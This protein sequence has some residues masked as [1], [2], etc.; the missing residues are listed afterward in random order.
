MKRV[1]KI[2]VG[3]AVL[4]GILL[5]GGGVFRWWMGRPMYEPGEVRGRADL[6][7]P[8]PREE[9]GD[10][11]RWKVTEDVELAWFA[12][13]EGRP[14]LV[15]HGG[16]G[17]P[18]VEPWPLPSLYERF[19]FYYWAQRGS[20][21]STRPFDRF[22]DAS[23][24][25]VIET[26]EAK[27]GIGAQL[28]DVERIRR[29]L[30]EERLILVGHSFG[31]LLASLY[32]AEFPDRVERLVLVAP[33]DALVLPSEVDF[34]ERIENRLSG[35]DRE[36]W[37]VFLDDLLDFGELPSRTEAELVEQQRTWARFYAKAT[38]GNTGP[39]LQR[40]V[41]GAGGWVAP[42]IYVGLGM[43]HDWRRALQAVKSPVLIL[44]GSED[45][46]P[47][48]RSGVYLDAFPNAEIEVIEGAGHFPHRT[49]PAQVERRLQRFMVGASAR[50][51]PP[52]RGSE[53]EPEPRPSP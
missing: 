30:E 51:A 23:L 34:F 42:A 38:H 21:A 52:V 1:R 44:H 24:W 26:I 11:G 6:E 35:E 49:H 53:G 22:E 43:R 13:G 29:I 48:S 25:E 46:M 16:P 32:A 14:V 8:P 17:I 39:A 7:P 31:A 19:R 2:W 27:L 33:A 18:E 47:P 20:G 3:I 40:A 37:N 10:H 15:M 28:A 12:R 41:E 5:V 9:M 4:V 45:L 50:A 36:G